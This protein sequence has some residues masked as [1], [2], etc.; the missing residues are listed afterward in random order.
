MIAFNLFPPGAQ[1]RS[2]RILRHLQPRFPPNVRTMYRRILVAG[3]VGYQVVP[4]AVPNTYLIPLAL[5]FPGVWHTQVV[6]DWTGY[7]LYLPT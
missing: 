7:I 5:F 4:T 6:I 3:T 1:V 2:G